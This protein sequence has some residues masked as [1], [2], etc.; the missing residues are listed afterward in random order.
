MRAFF[1]YNLDKIQLMRIMPSFFSQLEFPVVS[2]QHRPTISLNIE[3][4]FICPHILVPFSCGTKSQLV[5]FSLDLK[6][7]IHFSVQFTWIFPCVLRKSQRLYHSIYLCERTEGLAMSQPLDVKMDGTGGTGQV[8]C[9]VG[10]TL[11]WSAEFKH[12]N[13]SANAVHVCGD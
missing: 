1:L 12:R 10:S 6:N 13:I 8:C 5:S 7:C 9:P 2:G 3:A 4:L 11:S